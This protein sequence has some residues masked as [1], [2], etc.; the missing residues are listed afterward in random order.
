MTSIEPVDRSELLQQFRVAV[1]ETG[2]LGELRPITDLVLNY[3][4]PDFYAAEQQGSPCECETVL[5]PRANDLF[6]R[7]DTVFPY[8]SRSRLVGE[9]NVVLY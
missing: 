1:V 3:L 6:E 7:I 8:I 5:F 2:D 9:P 4:S